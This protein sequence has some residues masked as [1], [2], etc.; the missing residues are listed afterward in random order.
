MLARKLER[1]ANIAWFIAGLMLGL[2]VAC[3]LVADETTKIR[4]L[5][6]SMWLLC[7]QLCDM[8]WVVRMIKY[9]N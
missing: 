8:L 4:L 3:I 2:T 6:W 7:L 1:A 9:D 5:M